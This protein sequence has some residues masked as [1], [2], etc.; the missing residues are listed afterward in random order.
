MNMLWQE[1]A[2]EERLVT[3]QHFVKIFFGLFLPINGRMA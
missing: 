3:R 1:K 2:F